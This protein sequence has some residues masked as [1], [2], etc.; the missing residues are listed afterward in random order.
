MNLADAELQQKNESMQRKEKIGVR[1]GQ[2][3]EGTRKREG[4]WRI[5]RKAGVREGE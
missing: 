5:K 2:G 3:Y 1:E 4:G